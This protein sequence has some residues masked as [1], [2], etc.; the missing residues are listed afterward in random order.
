MAE[1]DTRFL[2][3]R[4]PPSVMQLSTFAHGDARDLANSPND[5]VLRGSPSFEAS[6]PAI[7][8]NNPSYSTNP[9]DGVEYMSATKNTQRDW[10]KM[11]VS[12]WMWAGDIQAASGWM[13][14]Q[15]PVM[16]AI[17]TRGTTYANWSGHFKIIPYTPRA[18]NMLRRYITN[19]RAI[20]TTT[21][22]HSGA[23]WT[24]VCFACDWSIPQAKVYINGTLNSST[25]T[26]AAGTIFTDPFEIRV[27]AEWF[28][29]YAIQGWNGKLSKL[30]IFEGKT[31]T[32]AEVTE[33]YSQGRT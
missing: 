16:S 2:E 6:P 24:H 11:S 3:R 22:C 7:Y 17:R 12:F 4:L 19:E 15:P 18:I 1:L 27:G 8:I 14:A 29:N 5:G 32:Q 33:I 13:Y 23:T 20:P 25:I 26:G 28:S 10:Q 31:L 9:P 30:I 21:N